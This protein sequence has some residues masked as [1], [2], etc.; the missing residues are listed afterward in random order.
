MIRGID[1][2]GD[3][4]EWVWQSRGI[5]YTA[6][7]FL[8]TTKY[9]PSLLYLLMTLGP[10]ILALAV[11]EAGN[12]TAPMGLQKFFITF[13]RVPL[14]FYLLQWP[15]AHLISLLLHFAAGKPTWWL[16]KTPIDWN[17]IGPDMGFNLV[18]VYLSWI[19]GVL[20]LYPLCKWFA[21]VKQRR[22]DWWLSYL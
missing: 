3:P 10:A 6:L 2:Y 4:Q 7:S 19:A 12:A 5:I 8:N 11:F 18:V 21:G 20:L 1:I 9:P 16:F 14:F 15:T 17:N 13:G 22:R